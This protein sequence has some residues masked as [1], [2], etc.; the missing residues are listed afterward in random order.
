VYELRRTARNDATDSE[1]KIHD[2]AEA[3]KLGLRGGLVPGVTLYAYC[4]QLLVERHGAGWLERGTASIRLIR[5]VYEGDVVLCRAEESNGGYELSVLGPEQVLCAPGSAAAAG[6][7]PFEPAFLEPAPAA[8]PGTSARPWLTRE[9]APIGA[10]LTTRRV[11]FGPEEASAYADM[12]DDPHP[13]YRGSSRGLP[14][15]PPGLLASQPARLLRE[16][17]EYGPSVH[18][19]SEIHHLGPALAGGEYRIDAVIRETST[20]RESDYL[21]ADVV[22]RDHNGVPVVQIRHTVIF[23]FAPRH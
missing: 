4:T 13:C 19:A 1:N 14:Y 7:A 11:H 2:D 20:R 5:P 16:N 21:C 3:Q 22:I 10:P 18:T 15:V 12:S 8:A 23:R 6:G 17:F 9:S